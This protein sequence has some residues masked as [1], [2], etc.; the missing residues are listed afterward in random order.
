MGVLDTTHIRFGVGVKKPIIKF[1]IVPIFTLCKVFPYLFVQKN[2][3][4]VFLQ[5]VNSVNVSCL[6][7]RI[8][9]VH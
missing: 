8:C 5:V 4:G 9:L 6:V 7:K 1:T 2:V 3:N